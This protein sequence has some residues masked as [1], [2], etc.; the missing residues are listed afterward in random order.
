MRRHSQYLGLLSTI[1]QNEKS[2]F[3]EIKEK[4]PKK[5]A[6]WQEKLFSVG[7][8]EVLIEA[9]VLAISTY[10]RSLSGRSMQI[11]GMMYDKILVGNFK[12]EKTRHTLE[13]M[14]C[15]N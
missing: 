7:G 14:E 15:D 12:G 3:G 5:L 6:S 1:E 8:K 4:V 2:I 13:G 11:F 10:S 9:M